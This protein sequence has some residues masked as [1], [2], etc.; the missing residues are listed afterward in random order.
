MPTFCG[1]DPVT[2]QP[3]AVETNGGLIIAVRQTGNDPNDLWIAPG[4]VDLQV[5]GYGGIDLNSDACGAED[6]LRLTKVLTANGTTTYLPT[7]ITADFEVMC[8]R[9]DSISRARLSNEAVSHAVPCLHLE[10]PSLSPEEGYRGAHPEDAVRP[11]SVDEFD[12]LQVAARGLI[13]LVTL[14]PHWP[15]ST[16]FIR[17]LIARGVAVAIG[18]TH[19]SPQQIT[20]AVDAGA[21]LS[22]HLGNG[23]AAQLPRHPNALWTQLAEDR[24]TASFIADGLHLPAD[25]F[26]VMLRAKGVSK[27]VLVSD[28]VAL[29]GRA[30]GVYQTH[31][32]GSVAVHKDGSIRMPSTG[33]LAGSSIAL[34]HAVARAVALSGCSLGEAVRMA[35]RNPADVLSLAR[36]R[37]QAGQ[38]ADILLFRWKPGD[39]ALQMTE[40]V[41]RGALQR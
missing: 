17:A 36:G 20:D 27:S 15:D 26:R 7:I 1:R 30:P 37:L 39:T 32:G 21:R 28:A 18:H 25:T 10:G 31:I 2:L 22:T 3:L 14:S 38:P 40:V 23:I 6:I 5:N 19:A 35:T 34:Q 4:L 13:R 41:V 16:L 8:A 29:A 11:P 33:L 12:A 9:L 24:L